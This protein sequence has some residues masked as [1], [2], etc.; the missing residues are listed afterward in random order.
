MHATGH[1]CTLAGI[2]TQDD[3]YYKVRKALLGKCLLFDCVSKTGKNWSV[4]CISH[5][6]STYTSNAHTGHRLRKCCSSVDANGGSKK[7]V[8]SKDNALSD[9]AVTLGM[10]ARLGRSITLELSS[11]NCDCEG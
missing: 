1:L 11:A 6:R 3:L 10:Y 4:V 2:S 8:S 9:K 5:L 7:D